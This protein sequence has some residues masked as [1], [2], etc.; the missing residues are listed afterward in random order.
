MSTV[1]ASVVNAIASLAG[2]LWVTKDRLRVLE[3]VLAERGLDVA[4]AVER[5]Q[6]GPQLAA[7]LNQTRQQFIADVMQ[8]LAED[9]RT[10]TRQD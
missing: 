9:P 7:E 4:D 1:P 5:Y 3:A 2:E 10:D 6:P 8:S